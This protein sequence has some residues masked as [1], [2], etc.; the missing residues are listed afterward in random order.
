MPR[1]LNLTR[2]CLGFDTRIELMAKAVNAELEYWV[3]LCTAGMAG[4]QPS[5]I[6]VETP[7]AT[8]AAAEQMLEAIADNLLLQGY[9]QCSSPAI[10]RLHAQAKLKSMSETGEARQERS[11]RR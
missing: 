9:E 7:F 8:Q 3:V 6:K 1:H 10:W 2:K 11:A 4:K 5:A